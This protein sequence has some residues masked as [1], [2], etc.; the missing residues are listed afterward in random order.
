[1]S[2]T[3]SGNNDPTFQVHVDP[4]AEGLPAVMV[5]AYGTLNSSIA[6]DRALFALGMQREHLLASRAEITETAIEALRRTP[7]DEERTALILGA[8]GCLDI[9]L[10]EIV[11]EF[12]KTTVVDVHT[13]QTEEALGRLPSSLLGK[14]SLVRADLSGLVKGVDNVFEQASKQE[15]YERFVE[16][17]AAMTQQLDVAGRAELGGDYSFVCSQL[18]MTQLAFNPFMHLSERVHAK[19]GKPL[20]MGRGNND[21]D[22]ARAIDEQS[23]KSQTEH[24]KQLHQLVADTGTVHLA[25]TWAEVRGKTMLPMVCEAAVK[26][27][28]SE[29]SNVRDPN[30][31]YYNAS[32]KLKHLVGSYALAPKLPA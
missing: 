11:T 16:V 2:E 10:A 9:P 28:Q 6:D 27:I 1:M 24:L 18:L 14:V 7:A 8:G 32:L 25:D 12:D 17:A 3:T 4:S 20:A 23:I 29:F 21:K 13:E 31:W 5:D 22:L 30:M 15:D 26:T 19:Y